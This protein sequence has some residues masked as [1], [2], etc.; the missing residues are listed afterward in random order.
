MVKHVKMVVQ[1]QEQLDI[2]IQEQQLDHA[3]VIVQVN[4]LEQIVKTAYHVII[5]QHVKTVVQ[6]QQQDVDVIVQVDILE[7]IVKREKV[8]HT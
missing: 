2:Q 3:D 5:F 8:A 4:V 7:Q 1:Q 6:Q